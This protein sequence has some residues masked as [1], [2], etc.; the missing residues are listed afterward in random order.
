MTDTPLSQPDLIDFLD[1]LTD[2]EWEMRELGSSLAMPGDVRFR[3]V[4]TTL[5]QPGSEFR[6]GV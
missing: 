2:A 3:N 1:A 4:S 5:I 6:L